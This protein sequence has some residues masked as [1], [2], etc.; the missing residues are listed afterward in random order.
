MKEK[1]ILV[2]S[3]LLGLFMAFSGFMKFVNNDMPKDMPA[4]AIKTIQAFLETKWLM[5]LVGIVELIGGILL[6]IPKTRIIG[7]LAL[8]PVM[9]GIALFNTFQTP[10]TMIFGFGI[11][12]ILL[13]ILGSNCN[14]IA[15]LM[16]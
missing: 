14:K 16:D 7:A 12:A 4:E 1:I 13:F 9:V 10:N 5:P 2:L 11:L 3:I 15:K 6:A 8:L